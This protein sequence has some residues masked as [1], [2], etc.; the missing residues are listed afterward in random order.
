MCCRCGPKKSKN[1]K[2]IPVLKAVSQAELEGGAPVTL[3]SIC[4]HFIPVAPAGRPPGAEEVWRDRP[5]SPEAGSPTC[6]HAHALLTAQVLPTAGNG[7]NLWT[8][9]RVAGVNL[10]AF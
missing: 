10:L 3:S 7:T 9:R 8:R 4:M 1:K 5:V 2:R 6:P